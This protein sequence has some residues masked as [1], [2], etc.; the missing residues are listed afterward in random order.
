MTTIDIH[1]FDEHPSHREIVPFNPVCLDLFA[2]VRQFVEANI[3]TVRLVHIGSSAIADLRG[4]PMIDIAAISTHENL[5]AEQ[6]RF[7]ALG[8]HRRDVWTDTDDKPYV[9]GSIIRDGSTWNVNI[10]ICRAGDPVHRDGV[11]FVEIMQERPDLRRR[12]ELAKDRAHRESPT[13]PQQYNEAK[14]WFF[15]EFEREVNPGD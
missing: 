2:Q 3:D 14:E 13:D 15:R 1:P 8:F 11:R 9:C 6:K 10:H 12:Y 5:R 4:K 7:E